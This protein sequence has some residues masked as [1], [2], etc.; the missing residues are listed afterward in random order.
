M[1][2]TIGDTVLFL[3]APT[4]SFSLVNVRYLLD[5]HGHSIDEMPLKIDRQVM[6][7]VK[8]GTSLCRIIKRMNVCCK[9]SRAHYARIWR[10][11]VLFL[12]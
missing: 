11:V 10:L 12:Y 4:N 9:I 5:D 8:M 7:Q 1:P 2:V 3:C 6:S